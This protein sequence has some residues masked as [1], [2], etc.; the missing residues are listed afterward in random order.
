MQTLK[1]NNYEEK[2]NMN[3]ITILGRIGQEPELRDVGEN[4]VVKLS[5]AVKS[6]SK[7]GDGP[8]QE[9][10]TWFS[11]IAWNKIAENCAKYL[12]KGSQVAVEGRMSSRKYTPEGGAE[13]IVWELVAHKVHFVGSKT[14]KKEEKKSDSSDDLP[15]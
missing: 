14:E 11:V 10:T 8:T 12:E 2:A 3:N 6:F 7:R 4:K 13:K 9:D 1:Y 15:W 5:V